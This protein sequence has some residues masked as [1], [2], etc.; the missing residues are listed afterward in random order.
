MEEREEFKTEF[1]A[2]EVE[3][4]KAAIFTDGKVVEYPKLGKL[5]IKFPTVRE[6]GE[7]SR[8]YA[9]SFT[10]LLKEGKLLPMKKLMEILEEQGIWGEEEEKESQKVFNLYIS[11]SVTIEEIKMKK[12]KSNE[13]KVNLEELE[14]ERAKYYD[15]YLELQIQKNMHLENCIEKQAEQEA[16]IYKLTKCVFKEDGTLKWPSYDDF[17]NENT[18]Q[19][20]DKLM[21]DAVLY[22]RG[23]NAPLSGF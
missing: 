22:W 4:A 1:S 21:T 15:R 19:E 3:E 8:F 16:V 18:E 13:D 6:D 17:Q 5:I 23:L 20:V 2:G 12:R 14:T 11:K 9:N 10:R 7:I